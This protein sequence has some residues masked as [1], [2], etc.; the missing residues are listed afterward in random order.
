MLIAEPILKHT[1]IFT[2]TYYL[3]I[4]QNLPSF[5]IPGFTKI[6]LTL[7]KEMMLVFLIGSSL[8]PF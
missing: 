2:S 7:F 3:K 1:F 4:S 6:F 8:S 5:L